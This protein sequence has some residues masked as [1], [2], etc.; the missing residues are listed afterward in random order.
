MNTIRLSS[1]PRLNTVL[2]RAR[3]APPPQIKAQQIST[4]GAP[5]AYR[6]G[7]PEVCAIEV[8]ETTYHPNSGN[9][10]YQAVPYASLIDGARDRMADVLQA[11]PVFETYALN[12]PG[13]QMFGMIGFG[14]GHTGEAIT[15]AVRSSY[16]RSIA[17]Q[18]AIGSSP[19]VCANGCFSGDHMISAKHTT[20]VFD[21]LNGMLSD[22][23][24]SAVTPVIER[25]QMIHGWKDI[26]VHHDL[27]GAY[28]GILFARNLI[29]P[30][31]FNAAFRYWNA[32][33][34]GELHE[35]H[36]Q[37][38]LFSAYQAVTAA[39]ARTPPS[40]AF[41]TFAGVDHATKAIAEAGG[42]LTDA[43]IPAFNL[44]IREYV[45]VGEAK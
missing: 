19:F 37:N 13:T 5:D 36:G 9:A 16:N 4:I 6:V 23:T 10:Q 33:H 44:N 31:S 42:S 34:S 11:D 17:N 45:D 15:V 28:M 29:T 25:I 38:N 41:R 32:C 20:N 1:A 40:Q 2:S 7:Y 18:V 14:S 27:F 8:P 3:P 43:Y 24:E 22:I 35:Q 26:P 21:T 12:G 30:T 39:G